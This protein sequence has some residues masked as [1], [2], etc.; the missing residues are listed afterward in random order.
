MKGL[1]GPGASKQAANTEAGEAAEGM[2]GAGAAAEA[3]VEHKSLSPETD[4][5]MM[6]KLTIAKEIHFCYQMKHRKPA[7]AEGRTPLL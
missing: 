6:K 5:P 4:F 3:A 1:G 7:V 2:G